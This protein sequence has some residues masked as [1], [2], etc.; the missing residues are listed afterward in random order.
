MRS[1]AR[2]LAAAMV[3]ALISAACGVPSAGD[4]LAARAPDGMRIAVATAGARNVR[5]LHVDGGSIVR[6]REV[7]VPDGETIA[8]IAWSDDGRDLVVT[9]RGPMYAVDTRTWRIEPSAHHQRRV[10]RDAR[11]G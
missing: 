4:S 5:V 1:L 7:F 2:V 8:A 11:R 6:L 9:T 3:A 10:A